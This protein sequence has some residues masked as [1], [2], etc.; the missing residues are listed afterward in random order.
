MLSCEEHELLTRVGPGTSLG[1]LLRRYWQPVGL[2]ELVTSKPQRMKTLGEELLLYRGASGKVAVTQLRCAHRSLALDY[3]RVEGDC[4]RCPYHGWLYD[5]EGHCLEQPA[6]PQGSGFK[7]KIKLKAYPAQ[8]ISGLV[9]AYMGPGEAPVLPTYDLFDMEDSVKGAQMRNVNANW[10]NAAENIV[11]ISHLSWLHGYTFPAYGAKKITY[12]WERKDYGID[13]VLLIDGVPDSHI[14][15][16]AFPNVNRFSGPPVE[17]DGSIVNSMIWRVPMDDESVM[18]YFLRFYSSKTKKNFKSLRSHAELGKYKPLAEDWWGIDVSD[19]DR[20]A[21]EQQG[22]R[23]DRENEH[24]GVSDGGII[25]MRKLIRES[26]ASIEAGEDPLGVIRDPAKH[27]IHFP[28]KS[29]AMAQRSE[30]VAYG[31]GLRQDAAE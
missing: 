8:E 12:H 10:L 5:A 6:E 28:H 19:Q 4:I 26:M 15:C 20:M 18:Q 31:M 17:E 25:L 1:E 2:S 3:G 21:V 23:A 29:P 22:L 27:H 14:S 13:N 30:G 7:D 16:Y 9:F 11:D 24:L